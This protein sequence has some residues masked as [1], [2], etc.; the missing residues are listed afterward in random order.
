MVVITCCIQSM[1]PFNISE[2]KV[3]IVCLLLSMGNMIQRLEGF[4]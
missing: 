1:Q 4:T 3:N 2:M